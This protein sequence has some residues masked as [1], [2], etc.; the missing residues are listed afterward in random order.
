MSRLVSEITSIFSY[1]YVMPMILVAGSVAGTGGFLFVASVYKAPVVNDINGER[2]ES[3][4]E[5][6]GHTIGTNT[7]DQDRYASESARAEAL[8]LK[9][10][11]SEQMP[12]GGDGGS[13]AGLIS[14]ILAAQED[15]R[16]LVA[17]V[18]KFDGTYRN[19]DA[20]QFAQ[21][22]YFQRNSFSYATGLE[23][24]TYQELQSIASY[25]RNRKFELINALKALPG[26]IKPLHDASKNKPEADRYVTAAD[27]ENYYNMFPSERANSTTTGLVANSNLGLTDS[28]SLAPSGN[29]VDSKLSSDWTSGGG[30]Q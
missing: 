16:A 11:N 27:L 14:E 10:R 26:C 5:F 20:T 21:N 19:C 7:E 13:L 30:K 29:T 28:S 3:V 6:V 23:G 22:L 8:R 18:T 15:H 25:E 24:K 12:E 17:Q 9:L 1:K 4:G 2:E